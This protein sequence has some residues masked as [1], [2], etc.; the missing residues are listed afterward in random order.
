MPQHGQLLYVAGAARLVR[1]REA[2]EVEDERVDDLVRERVLL[3]EQD[4]DEE[5]VWPGV[6]H[7]RE[8]DER[9][10]GVH[11]RHLHFREHGRDDGRLLQR[12]ARLNVRQ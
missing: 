5:R 7:V 2:D 3:V 4:A 1:V 10:G 11:Q 9:R 6:V 12:A 8:P